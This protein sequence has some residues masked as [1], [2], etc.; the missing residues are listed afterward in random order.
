[1]WGCGLRTRSRVVAGLSASVLVGLLAFVGWQEGIPAFYRSRPVPAVSAS[2]ALAL[3]ERVYNPSSYVPGTD[4]W[5]PPGP[6][7][8]VFQGRS[9]QDGFLGEI[10]DPWYSVSARDGT[11][12]RLVAPHLD[13]ATG[14]LWLAPDGT[15]VAWAWPGGVATYDPMTGESTTR[16]VPGVNGSTPLVWAPDSQMIAVGTDPVRLLRPTGALFELPLSGGAG[17]GEPAW[18]ADGNAVTVTRGDSIVSFTLDDSRRTMRA[19]VGDLRMPEWNAAGV[20]AGVHQA[21]TRNVLRIVD[22]P[23]P[24][25]GRAAVVDESPEDVVIAGFWGWVDNDEV[26]LTGLRPETGAIEQAIWVSLASGSSDTFTQLPTGAD[27]W[28]GMAT[29]SV[30]GDLLREPTQ[31]FESPTLPW[32]P[33]AKLLLCLLVAVFPTVYYLIARRP[34]S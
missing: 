8:L 7:S 22:A 12:R 15:A 33:G 32:S 34:R 25:A 26:V 6:V 5:G 16:P 17:A 24:A 20:L 18:T 21:Q 27:N 19:P 29:V 30:A 1:V 3:P 28:V 11:Y 9:A 4:Q 31:P 14:R 23:P 2:E 13:E 10:T